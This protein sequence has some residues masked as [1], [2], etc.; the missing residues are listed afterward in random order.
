MDSNINRLQAIQDRFAAR[1]VT[2]SRKF[3]HITPILKQLCWMLVKDHLF[4]RDALLAFKGMN[5]YGM[6][7]T[8]F[9]SRFIKTG[10]ISGRSTRNTTQHILHIVESFRSYST[11]D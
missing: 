7:P 3:D 10:T 5:A 1:I 8:N 9:N 2:R 4:Y 6:A 11:I